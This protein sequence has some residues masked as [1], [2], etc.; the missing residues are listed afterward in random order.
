MYRGSRGKA[1]AG[2]KTWRVASVETECCVVLITCSILRHSN[3]PPRECVAGTVLEPVD[4]SC[5]T[6]GSVAGLEDDSL[7]EE[8]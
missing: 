3:L 2:R 4:E 6:R 5:V 7:Q 8:C 1:S